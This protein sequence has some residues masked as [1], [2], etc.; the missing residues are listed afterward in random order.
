MEDPRIT[1][2]TSIWEDMLQIKELS[3]D[4]LGENNNESLNKNV[5]ES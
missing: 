3:D 2:E 1:D 4:I 5:E